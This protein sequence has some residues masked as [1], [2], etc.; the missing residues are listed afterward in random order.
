MDVLSTMNFYSGIAMRAAMTTV[1]FPQGK[2]L[3]VTRNNEEGKTLMGGNMKAEKPSLLFILTGLGRYSW[4]KL[5]FL[6][7]QTFCAGLP[8]VFM[9]HF[10]HA[11][12][13]RRGNCKCERAS[14]KWISFFGLYIG[15]CKYA[16]EKI[17]VRAL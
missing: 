15:A 2:R 8:Q 17:I 7:R 3:K 5:P 9:W 12:H 4:Y 14:C 16:R 1:I 6:K 10:H 13:Y 11:I